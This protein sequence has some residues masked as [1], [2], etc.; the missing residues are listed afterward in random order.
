M[1]KQKRYAFYLFIFLSTPIC[2]LVFIQIFQLV[3]KY[4]MKEK[5]EYQM[6][7]RV[8]IKKTDLVWVKKNSEILLEGRMFDVKSISQENDI[9]HI[10][11][12]FDDEETVIE[13]FIQKNNSGNSTE[14]QRTLVQIFQVFQ[15]L[16]HTELLKDQIV[17]FPVNKILFSENQSALVDHIS[18]VN[19][20]PPKI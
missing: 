13:N 17:L 6:L 9:L 20:P 14:Q 16:I 1:T 18:K 5:L 4:E 2:S 15:S 19:T 12:L 10:Q 3:I 8:T 7:H 11:G